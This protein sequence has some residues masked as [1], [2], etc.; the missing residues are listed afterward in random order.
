MRWLDVQA[1]A[2]P[3]AQKAMSLCTL[4]AHC[5]KLH[6][7]GDMEAIPAFAILDFE[8]PLGTRAWA[9]QMYNN[10]ETLTSIK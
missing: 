6:L 2:K 9:R 3:A 10:N 4:R 7:R 1:I 5:R 8:R